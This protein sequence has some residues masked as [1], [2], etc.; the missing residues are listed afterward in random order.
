ML[1]CQAP[2]IPMSIPILF[3]SPQNWCLSEEFQIYLTFNNIKPKDWYFVLHKVHKQIKI[4]GWMDQWHHSWY[5]AT[6]LPFMFID[7]LLLEHVLDITVH[8]VNSWVSQGGH[9]E[10]LLFFALFYH[11]TLSCLK[12]VGEVGW[13]PMWFWCQPKVQIFSFLGGLLFNLGAGW[14]KGLDLDQGLTIIL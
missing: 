12:V 9:S 4:F 2:N 13:W 11:S 7:K 14:D 10:Q 3:N 5:P 1:Y 6:L 8:L